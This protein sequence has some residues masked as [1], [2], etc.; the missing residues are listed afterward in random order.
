MEQAFVGVGDDGI[1]VE[2]RLAVL[3]AGD[4]A[5]P[6]RL[7]AERGGKLI[8]LE[9][10]DV[11]TAVSTLQAAGAVTLNSAVTAPAG[12][13]TIAAGT[14]T[15]TATTGISLVTRASGPCLS[16]PAA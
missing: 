12:G 1:G 9:T 3:P 7:A 10:S 2:Y 5:E 13:L 6:F 15:S 8:M 14:G 11:E 4:D 16:S